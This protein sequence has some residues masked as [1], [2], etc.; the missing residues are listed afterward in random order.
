[1]AF[2]QTRAAAWLGTAVVLFGLSAA[3]PVAAQTAP[4]AA[5]QFDETVVAKE[6]LK[7]ET[8]L[9]ASAGGVWSAGNTKQITLNAGTEGRFVRGAHGIGGKAALVYGT[10]D[11]TGGGYDETAFNVNLRLRYDFYLTD[12]DAL[13][14]AAVYRHDRFAGLDHRAEGQV[15]YQRHFF[16]EDKHRGWGEAGYDITVDRVYIESVTLDAMM[17][18]IGSVETFDWVDP[19]HAAR[20]YLGYENLLNDAVTLRTGLEALINVEE[21]EDTRLNWDNTLSSKLVGSLS[22]E[23]GFLLQFDNVPVPGR[24][25]VDTSTKLNLV[26]TFI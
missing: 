26:Y 19:V 18:P 7:D 2:I 6:A 15:G 11:T 20:L 24:K 4:E 16:R 14:G 21:P 10:A 9:N 12:Y 22:V 8:T 1:M 25:K 23:L 13:F 3:A 17:A 5:K